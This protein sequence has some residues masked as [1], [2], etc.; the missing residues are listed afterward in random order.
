MS[1]AGLFNAETVVEWVE[2]DQ[3]AAELG[4]WGVDYLQGFRFGKPTITPPWLVAETD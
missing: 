1:L 4:T 3:S 2:D